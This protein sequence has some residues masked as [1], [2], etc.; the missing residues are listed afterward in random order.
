MSTLRSLTLNGTLPTDLH[1]V[2][3][4]QDPLLLRDRADLGDRLDDADLV[5]GRHD[6]DED[7]LVGDRG[8]QL[9][10]ADAAVLLHRQ[11][12]DAVAVLLEPLARV[13]HRLVLGHRT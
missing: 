10:E 13:D 12:G 6:R 2:G 8:L 5:V 1:R 4:E 9:V 11:I 3:V 7:R